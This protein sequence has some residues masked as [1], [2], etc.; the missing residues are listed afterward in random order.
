ML[1]DSKTAAHKMALILIMLKKWVKNG[2]KYTLRRVH[3]NI[4]AVEKQ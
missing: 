4:L 1:K 3:V 2:K